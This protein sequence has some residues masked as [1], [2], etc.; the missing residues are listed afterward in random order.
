MANEPA[1]IRNVIQLETPGD[2]SNP[3]TSVNNRINDSQ[4]MTE[5]NRLR[6][7]KSFLNNEAIVLGM[8][9]SDSKALGDLFTLV[10]SSSGRSP[11]SGEGT[12]L[13]SFSQMFFQR[14][15]E[16]QRRRFLLGGIPKSFARLP[17]MFAAIALF[18]LLCSSVVPALIAG[19]DQKIFLGIFPFYLFWL[20]SLG[21]IGSIAFVGMNALS[22]Q[23]DITF[24][25]LNARLINLRIALGALFALVLTL[26]YGFSGYVQ[27][28]KSLYLFENSSTMSGS[29]AL[30]LIVPFLL[31]FSTSLVIMIMNRL[32]EAAQSF[33][34][35]SM[36]SA[37]SS[38]TTGT[39]SSGIHSS[40]QSSLARWS[41]RPSGT[42]PGTIRRRR[43]SPPS[44][45][46]ND[47]L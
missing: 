34:G 16:S 35:K 25:L 2:S 5:V 43:L 33:F 7:L 36:A 23:Q 18:S 28:L 27:F 24:D 31:G 26:P 9:G 21:A 1:D 17:M 46:K 45:A 3:G 10:E 11:T 47:E 41:E 37:A 38:P 32:L 22:V 6:N 40:P 20:V 14:L 12:R 30:L 39:S 4:F 19:N 29:D 44:D 8:S 13:D 15:T 42:G